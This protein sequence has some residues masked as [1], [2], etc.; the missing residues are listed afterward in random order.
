MAAA[1]DTQPL[2]QDEPSTG[3]D[4]TL[5]GRAQMSLLDAASC[6]TSAPVTVTPGAEFGGGRSSTPFPG[7]YAEKR[8]LDLSQ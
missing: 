4:S 8:T 6:T 2:L 7:V 1:K 5:S 3:P